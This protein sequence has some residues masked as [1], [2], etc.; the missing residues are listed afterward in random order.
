MMTSYIICPVAVLEKRKNVIVPLNA[1]DIL[2]TLIRC[3]AVA[4]CVVARRERVVKGAAAGGRGG[5]EAAGLP[6]LRPLTPC[7]CIFSCLTL[8]SIRWKRFEHTE[9]WCL[10]CSLC[11]SMCRFRLRCAVKEIPQ[12][13]HR[14]I[15]SPLPPA[16]QPALPPAPVE[17]EEEVEV[18]LPPALF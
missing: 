2:M 8:Q 1:V 13:S 7:P 15:P 4:A 17:E 10:F 14:R 6:P 3:R 11:L 18:P 16:L 12:T 9:H 5:L